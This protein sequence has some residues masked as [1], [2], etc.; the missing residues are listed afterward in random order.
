MI[1][2][3]WKWDKIVELPH[4]Q[5]EEILGGFPVQENAEIATL[6][7]TFPIGLDSIVC[8]PLDFQQENNASGFPSWTSTLHFHWVSFGCPYW[9]T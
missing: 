1:S 9:E 2:Y 8:Y 6:A 3:P 5:D 4:F 7:N